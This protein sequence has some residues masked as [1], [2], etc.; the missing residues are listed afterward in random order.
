ML[1][2]S[3]NKLVGVERKNER[4]L[5]VHGILDDDIYSLELHVDI[6]ISDLEITAI[7]GLWHRWTTPECPRATEFLQTA[8]GMSVEGEDFTQKIFK[9][10][11]RSACRHYANLLAECCYSA[12][13]A[14]KL[15]TCENITSKDDSLKSEG[16]GQEVEARRKTQ[17]E[18]RSVPP[19][20]VASEPDK[21]AP[22]VLKGGGSDGT[23]I[24]LHVHTSPASPCSMAPVDQTIAEAKRIGL[25]GICLTDHNYVWD[26][27]DVEKLR[28]K[29][30]YLILRGNEITTEQGDILVFGLEKDIQGIIRLQDLR[31]GVLDAGGF[32]IAAHPFRGFLIVGIGKLGLTHKAAMARPVFQSVDAIEV[33][34]SKVTPKEND[35]ASQVAAKLG[36][37]ATGGSDAHAVAE[38]GIHATHFEVPIN[39]E[40]ELIQALKTGTY[41]PV[42]FR[43]EQRTEKK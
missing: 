14:A 35:F 41:R 22:L 16:A 40:R 11:G 9:T 33:L 30:G 43:K 6:R 18:S 1:K 27:T 25:D 42:S 36:M 31:R 12:K 4:T 3:R 29:H 10:V 28:Q 17:D 39:N 7:K 34:N 2:F 38:L 21:S 19:I 24:D 37:P 13:E 20:E 23:T 15:L 8:V 32:M 5:L 26:D